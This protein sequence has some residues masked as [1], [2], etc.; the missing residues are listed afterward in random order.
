M[1]YHT[2]SCIVAG[3]LLFQFILSLLLLSNA[4]ADDVQATDRAKVAFQTAITK[5]DVQQAKKILYGLEDGI[6]RIVVFSSQKRFASM[7]K[8]ESQNKPVAYE[9][10]ALF[11]SSINAN[12]L[13]KPDWN[14]VTTTTTTV[15]GTVKD[16]IT[17]QRLAGVKVIV[18]GRETTTDTN[19]VFSLTGLPEGTFDWFVIAPGF[20]SLEL[21]GIISADAASS[22]A[23]D[24]IL[25][26]TTPQKIVKGTET[27]D[28]TVVDAQ[29]GK[30][31]AGAKFVIAPVKADASFAKGAETDSNGHFTLTGVHVGLSELSIMPKDLLFHL[32]FSQKVNISGGGK[33]HTV[34]WKLERSKGEIEIP[35][36]TWFGI[37]L[38][39]DTE[40]PIE[41]ARIE[42]K[43]KWTVSDKDGHFS[44]ALPDTAESLDIKDIQAMA[45]LSAAEKRQALEKFY[46][47]MESGDTLQLDNSYLLKASHNSY[48]EFSE[49]YPAKRDIN[50]KMVIHLDPLNIGDIEGI[51]VDAITGKPVGIATVQVQ[52]Q[53]THSKAD[54]TF[55]FKKLRSGDLILQANAQRYQTAENRISLKSLDTAQIK[56]ELQPITVGTVMGLVVNAV[57][58]TPLAGATITADTQTAI[59]D[60]QGKFTLSDMRAGSRSIQ[61]SKP[62]FRAGTATVEVVAAESVNV[63]LKLDPITTGTVIGLALNAANQKPLADVKVTLGTLSV[64][65]N[66]KGQFKLADVRAG[67]VLLMGSKEVFKPVTQS[68][69]VLAA[70]NVDVTLK[71]EPI[72]VG[73]LMGQV[74]NAINQK[75]LAGATITAG[76]KSIITDAQGKFILS[77]MSVGPLSVQ[78]S[79]PVFKPS[80]AEVTVIAAEKV[81]VML[82]LEP[83]TTGVITGLALNAADKT[84]LANVKITLGTRTAMTDTQGRFE[85]KDINVGDVMMQASKTA[86]K[87]ASQG[88]KVVAAKNVNVTLRLEPITT[89]SINGIA[90][91]KNSQKPI[92][93]VRISIS[94][95]ADET[96]RNG[97]FTFKSVNI[98]EVQLLAQHPDYKT[99]TKQIQL[100]PGRVYEQKVELVR[101]REDVI[102]LESA[103][104]AKGTVDLYGIHFDSGKDQFKPSSLP[105]LQAVSEVI[106]DAS[107]EI[108][109]ISG[110]TDSD[111]SDNYNL[112]LSKRRAR[113]VMN[114]LIE[115]G[116]KSEQLKASGYGE[117]KPIVPNNNAAG[118][119]LNR[120]VQLRKVR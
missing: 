28:G 117:T 23:M 96:N 100:K 12:T 53:S 112:D 25:H 91:D 118:K 62:V 108:F 79:K 103:L 1:K 70:K 29:T 4:Y 74:I 86:F 27:I 14:S 71:F 60:V 39:S 46:A 52:N 40:E 22:R 55:S 63:T 72:T 119:A 81:T 50:K 84:P 3:H 7:K 6:S 37:V 76:T 20:A 13:Y 36:G 18:A 64:M 9:K 38:R 35:A 56:F 97:R 111:G 42:M 21:T 73:T 51:V 41:G 75:P 19:G 107:G 15:S 82:K 34:V 106:K 67:D 99:N 114:W 44:I 47:T 10:M 8:L 89:A 26:N 105:T 33:I 49:T 59:T 58:Q 77:D 61:A 85:L 43:K 24:F 90:V 32:P 57:D 87:P 93:G 78:A 92:S 30:P 16:D 110:H 5:G 17:S 31:I 65:T 102:E 45:T 66:T 69:K 11:L 88:V 83:I 2:F 104:R 116:V 48:S 115:H 94:N 98:G 80:T 120:R 54:G 113:T 101:R 109:E 95:Q 68:V